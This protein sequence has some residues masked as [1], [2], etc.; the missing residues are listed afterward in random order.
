M[1]NI[2]IYKNNLNL[3]RYFDQILNKG[4]KLYFI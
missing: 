2:Y 1:P 4:I 3:F